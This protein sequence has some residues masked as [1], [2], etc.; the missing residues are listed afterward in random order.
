MVNEED[1]EEEMQA[2]ERRRQ[3]KVYHEGQVE[4]YR[5]QQKDAVEKKLELGKICGQVAQKKL[6]LEA[7]ISDQEA[8]LAEDKNKMAGTEEQLEVLK[9]K[10]EEAEKAEE[11][12]ISQ[13]RF[14]SE[15]LESSGD[16]ED[17]GQ[18]D[19][20]GWNPRY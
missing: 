2:E 17:H 13:I 4:K 12:C 9:E 10:Y 8:K 20:E 15:L 18:E 6:E 1:V 3:K 5:E 14:W 7:S 16:E 19:G 11:F